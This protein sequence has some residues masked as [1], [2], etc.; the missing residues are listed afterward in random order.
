MNGLR[1]Y[2]QAVIRCYREYRRLPRNYRSY[3]ANK[4]RHLELYRPDTSC[5]R[6]PEL[7]RSIDEDGVAIVREFLPRDVAERIAGE[8]RPSI[9]AVA[10]DRYEGPL[11][12]RRDDEEGVFRLYGVE[13]A[14]SPSSREFFQSA[15][16]A[17]VANSLTVPG[18]HPADGY[19]DYKAKVGGHDV[20]VSYH[21]DHWK[22]R[23]KAFLLLQDVSEDQAPFVYVVGSHREER[24][25]RRRDWAY[26]H[27]EAAGSVLRP[28]QVERIRR[29]YG[30]EERVVTGR[31]GD[32]ILANT[33]GIHRGTVLKQ[34]T[35]LQLVN[36]YAMDGPPEYAC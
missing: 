26:Q 32:L 24:W 22:L 31:A 34:G 19:V 12:A 21:I 35:R 4:R 11:R 20:S 14:L 1:P 9:D 15:F 27:R 3:A 16:I 8:V 2:G 13:E 36:L 29:H 17:A 18:M 5:G 6:D 10:D 7:L 33:R 23:F 28:Q 25:R 30:Y